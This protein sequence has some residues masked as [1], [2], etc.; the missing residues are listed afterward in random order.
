VHHRALRAALALAL[1]GPG[2]GTYTYYKVKERSDSTG[3]GVL[4]AIGVSAAAI[5]A[6]VA[7]DVFIVNRNSGDGEDFAPPF[8]T[9]ALATEVLV[10]LI[11]GLASS[12]DDDE[13]R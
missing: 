3:L 9:I 4:A 2:C 6:G 8:T 11:W 7:A 10:P 5:T 13:I 1:A 12:L